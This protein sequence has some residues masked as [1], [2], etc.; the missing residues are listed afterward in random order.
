MKLTVVGCSGSFPG[1]DGPASCY[2]VEADGFRLVVDLGSGA[3]GPL[4]RHCEPGDL[5]AVL[6]SHLHP[7][8]CMDVLP[9]YVALTY[10]P[11]ATHDRLLVYGPAGA[12]AHLARAYGRCEEPGL[13]GAFDFLDLREGTQEV[14][15]FTVTAARTAHPIETWA[16]RIEHGGRILVYSADTGPTERLVTL[17]EGADVFLCEASYQEGGDNPA[18]LHLTGRQAGEHAARAGVRRLVITHVPVWNDP[19]RTLEE[20]RS[21]FGER[22]ELAQPGTSY[23]I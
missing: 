8:H 18:D 22:V 9:L 4:Q 15:P 7:D 21:S 1:P 20:A 19:A 13:T 16:M 2:L 17:A 3:L 11:V 5:D 14:G 6:L 10:D 23:K 12:G